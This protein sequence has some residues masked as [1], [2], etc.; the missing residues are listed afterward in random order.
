MQMAFDAAITE[1]P[2]DLIVLEKARERIARGWCQGSAKTGDSFC[3]I[4]SLLDA[5]SIPRSWGLDWLWFIPLPHYGWNW[6]VATPHLKLLGFA[7]VT[8]AYRWNDARE[9]TQPEVLARFDAAIERLS[10]T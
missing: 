4:G 6:E 1:K 9:R 2:R 10:T 5:A 7:S 8:D 3:V